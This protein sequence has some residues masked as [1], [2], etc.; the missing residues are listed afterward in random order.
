MVGAFC[1]C[2]HPR[3]SVSRSRS[4]F[5]QRTP[6]PSGPRAGVG[7]ILHS[8]RAA[9]TRKPGRP[10]DPVVSD[11][12]Q[13]PRRIATIRRDFFAMAQGVERQVERDLRQCTPKRRAGA[14]PAPIKRGKSSFARVVTHGRPTNELQRTHCDNSETARRARRGTR[15]GRSGLTGG[16]AVDLRLPPGR[17]VSVVSPLP[18]GPP[19]SFASSIACHAA[20]FPPPRP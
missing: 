17:A 11:G 8:N 6:S 9:I 3:E 19:P 20:R 4:L 16:R 14:K 5:F 10:I 18:A 2:S 1:R 13:R 7:T 12:G 15:Y